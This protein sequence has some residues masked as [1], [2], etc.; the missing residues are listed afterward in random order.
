MKVFMTGGTGFVGTYLTEA[1]VAKGHQLT[2]M[3]RRTREDRP[4]PSGAEYLEGDPTVQGA[5]QDRVAEHEV[6]INLA[7]TSIFRRWTKSAKKAI[8]ESRI[9]TTQNLVDALSSRQGM[10][11]ILLSTSAVG[12]Y[13]FHEDEDL[14]EESPPG[15][16]FLASLSVEWESLAMEAETFG[17]RVVPLRFGIVLGKNGGALKQMIPMFKWYLG[18]PLGSGKQ[19][20]SWIHIHDLTN[21][22]LYLMERQDISGPIDCTAPYPVQNADLTKALGE[23]LG[24]PTFMPAVPAFAMQMLMGEFGSILVKGQKVLPKRLLEKGFRFRFPEIRGAL[25]DLLG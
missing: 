11:T 18:S 16:D 1:M 14:D 13:G 3:T 22:Y 5:W 2:L 4:L 21:I 19:W 12:Y 8:R 9:L 20:F 17:V 15:D 6:V 23:A 7:G 25:Q 24:K 10:D